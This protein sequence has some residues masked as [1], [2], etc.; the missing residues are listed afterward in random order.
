MAL[1]FCHLYCIRVALA[2]ICSALLSGSFKCS[3]QVA[4]PGAPHHVFGWPLESPHVF[5]QVVCSQLWTG[6]RQPPSILLVVEYNILKSYG[7]KG[8]G[9]ARL[10]LLRPHVATGRLSFLYTRVRF[11]EDSDIGP[12]RPHGVR[13]SGSKRNSSSPSAV[14]FG[15]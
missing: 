10:L 6:D 4:Q 11:S 1:E 9:R 12:N 5:A 8:G 3:R 14:G 2:R 13:R 15:Q 7:S